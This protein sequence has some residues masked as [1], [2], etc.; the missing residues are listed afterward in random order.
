MGVVG[1]E[2]VAS[3]AGHDPLCLHQL[4]DEARQPGRH[5]LEAHVGDSLLVEGEALTQELYGPYTQLGL[6]LDE[7]VEGRA[8]QEGDLRNPYGLSIRALPIPGSESRLAEHLPGLQHA[9]GHFLSGFE[10][11]DAH[12]PFEEQEEYLTAVSG[13][14][15]VLANLEG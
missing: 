1:A 14:E 13:G 11:V 8:I 15:D 3:F 5:L 2:A 10:A 9:D 7:S 12:P 6:S 4:K